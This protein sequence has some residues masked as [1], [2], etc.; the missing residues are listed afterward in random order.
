MKKRVVISAGAGG[1]GRA[2]AEAFLA[3]GADVFVCD[4]DAE[5]LEDIQRKH[6]GVRTFQA[7]VRDPEAID[8]FFD[9]IEIE[10]RAGDHPG[11]DVLVNN[12]GVS[13]PTARLEDIALDDW[14]QT[15]DIDLNSFFYFSRRAIPMLRRAGGGSIVNMASNAAFFGFPLRSP[16]AACKWAV[17]GLTKTMAMELGGDQIRVN[18][19]CPCSVEG[20]RIQRVIEKDAKARGLAVETVAAEYK[21]QSSLQ[22]FV[23]NDDIVAMINFLTSPAGRHISGQAIGLDGHT[24]SLSLAIPE[25]ARQQAS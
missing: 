1:I 25:S 20:P 22:T 23:T 14:R 15:I 10:E 11:I 6:N 7:D 19:I 13:G 21:R 16:Y 8:A 2:V 12:A 5:A 18:A 4:Y 24:E 17:I 9:A 3:D